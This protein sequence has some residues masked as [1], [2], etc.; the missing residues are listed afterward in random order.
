ML[1][2]LLATCK[3]TQTA[4]QAA[5]NALDTDLTA[6]LGLMIERSE[7]ELA[8][9]TAKIDAL[10]DWTALRCSV[11]TEPSDEVLHAFVRSLLS[12]VI[13]PAVIDEAIREHRETWVMLYRTSLG[14]DVH[15]A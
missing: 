7:A 4:L 2:L 8:A 1:I 12:N 9:L 3:Q 15:D 13:E 11:D 5:S 10:S 6:D 14:M